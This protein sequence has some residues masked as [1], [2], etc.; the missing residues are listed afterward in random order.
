MSNRISPDSLIVC[1]DGVTRTWAER[2]AMFCRNVMARALDESQSRDER[3]Q[4]IL[5]LM[6]LA[7]DPL[8][9][10]TAYQDRFEDVSPDIAA[11]IA[12]LG[13][14]QHIVG[15]LSLVSHWRGDF[16]VALEAAVAKQSAND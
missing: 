8:I 6:L 2:Q 16:K 11:L 7:E 5:S 9:R 4:D 1:R 15:E 10:E 13:G 12:A 14:P 3:R